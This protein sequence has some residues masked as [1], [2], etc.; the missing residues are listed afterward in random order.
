MQLAAG[1]RVMASSFDAVVMISFGGPGG[2]DE[3]RPFLQNVVRGRRIPP[4]RIEEVAHHYELFDGV[5]P[6]TE[7]TRRQ[8]AGMQQ[9]L[10]DRGI[11]L[12]VFVGMRNW[13]PFLADTL[14]EMSAAGIR[15]VIGFIVAAHH[16]YSSC[17]QYRENVRDARQALAERGLPDVQVTYLE[18]W[19]DHPGFIAANAVHVREAAA[20]LSP[21][22]RAQARLVF[23]AH[24]IPASMADR[25][26]YADQVRT[27]AQLVAE[28]LEWAN[29]S[30]VWQSRSGRPQDPWLEPDICDYLKAEAARGLKAAVICPIGFLADHVEVLYDLDHEAAGLCRTLGLP[31]VRAETVNDDPLFLDMAADLVE[32]T[33]HR[34]ERF[35]PLP[36]TASSSRQ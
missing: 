3:I 21:G 23:T 18:S 27:S 20:Q 30:L 33:C 6:L 26:R 31:M 19:Y 11:A 8:A 17:Q 7:V 28:R 34:Y 15:H 14:A 24:S 9:R 35:A 5:S 2:P 1:M 13:H 25:C 16:S 4:A 22:L 29:W 12:P 10:A 36:I 32:R